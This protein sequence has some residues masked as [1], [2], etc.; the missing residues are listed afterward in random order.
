MIEKNKYQIKNYRRIIVYEL[1]KNNLETHKSTSVAKSFALKEILLKEH[2]KFKNLAQTW[3][4]V[5][6]V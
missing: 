6:S 2:D 1:P 5:I 3:G 4:C